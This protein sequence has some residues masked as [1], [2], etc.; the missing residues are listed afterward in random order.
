MERKILNG[1]R[2]RTKFAG[3]L[4]AATLVTALGAMPAFAG[5]AKPFAGVFTGNVAFTPTGATYQGSGT[6]NHLGATAIAGVVVPVGPASCDGFAAQQTITLT[7]ANGDELHIFVVD[8][9]CFESEVQIHGVGTFEVTGGTGRFAN[10][11]GAGTF[12]GLARLDLGTVN[13]TLNGTITY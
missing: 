11:T 5:D 1:A 9:S 13:I 6:A 3:A 12:D 4:V 7:A 2:R 10:A 8:D